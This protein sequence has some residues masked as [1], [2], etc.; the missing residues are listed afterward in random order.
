M[1]KNITFIIQGPLHLNSIQNLF[2]YMTYGNVIF[3]CWD[4]C[5]IDSFE[6]IIKQHRYP[7]HVSI[8]FIVNQFPKCIPQEFLNNIPDQS[9]IGG[10]YY[11]T[12]SVYNAL[13]TVKTE[14]VIKVRSDEY[15]E[16]WDSFINLMFNNTTKLITTNIFAFKHENFPLHISD[17]FF[18]CQTS[19]LLETYKQL[20]NYVVI[21]NLNSDETF[22]EFKWKLFENIAPNSNEE[23]PFE[24]YQEMNT[25]EQLISIHFL[26]SN[27]KDKIFHETINAISS[28]QDNARKLMS[29]FF[30]ICPV[31]HTQPF[32]WSYK[33][34]D[35]R[36]YVTQDDVQITKLYCNIYTLCDYFS[37]NIY[38]Q[39]FAKC[40]RVGQY[41]Y[42]KG[43]YD[44]AF[45][46]LEKI[47]EENRTA[48]IWLL[49]GNCKYFITK[50][51]ENVDLKNEVFLY[52]DRIDKNLDPF[53][54]ENM[55]KNKIK[56]IT[57][58]RKLRPIQE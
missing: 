8:K 5:D 17:H 26:Y 15:F 30:E 45:V 27:Y 32:M 47:P 46:H 39:Y 37:L 11:Q 24:F 23:V 50:Y 49:L 25:S 55:M 38:Y 29:T 14:W 18:G 10:M 13:K 19:L 43:W 52:W 6:K 35:K 28:N 41:L 31:Q 9:H 56:A 57:N 22:Y 21:N 12:I 4:T 53:I 54:Y 3:S 1:E 42:N 36:K 20:Y 40:T 2:I 7:K 44:K 48:N 51:F 34:N 16:N 58:S 33:D